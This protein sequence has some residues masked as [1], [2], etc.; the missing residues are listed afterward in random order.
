DIGLDTIKAYRVP[1]LGERVVEAALGHPHV[2]RHLPA[3]EAVDGN[4]GT[5]LLT[6]DATAAG[7]AQPR[8]DATAHTDLGLGG[9]GV[10]SDLIEFHIGKSL[11]LLVHDADEMSDLGDHAAHGRGIFKF[12][13]A[14]HLVEPKAHESRAL[15][16]LA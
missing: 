4:A 12:A 6:L 16:F 7:L 3:F 14:V 13:A 8:T 2:E 10:V 11:L 5:G 9:A 15:I 1:L